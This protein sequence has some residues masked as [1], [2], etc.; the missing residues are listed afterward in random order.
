[1][2][3]T[4]VCSERE[5]SIN[6]NLTRCLREQRGRIMIKPKRLYKGDKVAIV[7]LSRGMIG[8]K[9]FIHKYELAKKRLEEYGLEVVA[10]PN[11]LKGID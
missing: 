1:M 5:S 6:K 3:L 8:E 2:P 10:M 11:A 7:S 4:R 9:M